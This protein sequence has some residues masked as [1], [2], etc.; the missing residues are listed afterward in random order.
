MT[1]WNNKQARGYRA[2]DDNFAFGSVFRSTRLDRRLRSRLR[3]NRKIALPQLV[4]AMQDAA[5]VDLRGERVL[6]VVLRAL[7]PRAIR[8]PRLRRAVATLRAWRRAGSHRRD[9]DEDG[10]YESTRTCAHS[11]AAG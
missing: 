1:S 4:D 2:A 3:G 10:T 7:R 6:P 8:S 11:S 5:T 9:A